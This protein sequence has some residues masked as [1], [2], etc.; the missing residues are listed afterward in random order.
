LVSASYGGLYVIQVS[1]PQHPILTSRY[2]TGGWVSDVVTTD[3]LAFSVDG[4]HLYALDAS[5]PESPE[6]IGS[7]NLLGG[8]ELTVRGHYAFVSG[9][10]GPVQIFDMLDPYDPVMTGTCATGGYALSATDSALFVI[11]NYTMVIIDVSDPYH[12]FSTGEYYA[13]YDAL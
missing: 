5:H 11:R 2:D 7:C 13:Q 1:D 3:S 6:I 8:H 9:E 12:P 10:Y 4:C